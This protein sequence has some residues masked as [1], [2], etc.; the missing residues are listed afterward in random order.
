MKM[1]QIMSKVLKGILLYFTI[2]YF[3]CLIM[4][5][6]SLSVIAIVIGLILFVILL[7]ACY[8]ALNDD[9]L[10]NYVPKWFK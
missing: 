4:T 10:E 3:F 6:E 7:I 9:N 5:I 2:I 1:T 8:I